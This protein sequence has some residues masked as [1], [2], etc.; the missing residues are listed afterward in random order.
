M[1]KAK[2]WPLATGQTSEIFKFNMDYVREWFIWSYTEYALQSFLIYRIAIVV[3]LN[4]FF[5]RQ[6]ATSSKRHQAMLRSS[7]YRRVIPKKWFKKCHLASRWRINSHF[8][9]YIDY[10]INTCTIR[11]YTAKMSFILSFLLHCIR[12]FQF[13]CSLAVVS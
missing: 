6:A 9:Y 8:S 10:L 12:L 1:N 4:V 7:I 5:I 2:C 13:S 3:E 11:R